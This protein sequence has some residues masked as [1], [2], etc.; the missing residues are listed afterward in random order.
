MSVV[1]IEQPRDTTV[2][3]ADMETPLQ[4]QLCSQVKKQETELGAGSPFLVLAQLLAPGPTLA[5]TGLAW[6]AGLSS[7]KLG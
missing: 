2:C 3:K 7:L 6:P 4:T 5:Q 1:G